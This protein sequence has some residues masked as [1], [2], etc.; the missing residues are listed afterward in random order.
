[1]SPACLQLRKPFAGERLPYGHLV[2]PSSQTSVY[3]Y[4]KCTYAVVATKRR[5]TLGWP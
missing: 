3:M 5:F 4:T 1:M 2:N